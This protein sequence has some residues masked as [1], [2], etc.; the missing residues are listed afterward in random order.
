MRFVFFFL[1]LAAVLAIVAVTAMPAMEILG[2][3]TEVLKL[4]GR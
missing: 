2:Q 3:L 1:V 4:P